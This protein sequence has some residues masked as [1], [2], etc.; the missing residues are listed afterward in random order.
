MK[1][2]FKIA[3]ESPVGSRAKMGLPCWLKAHPRVLCH[4][5]LITMGYL[6]MGAAHNRVATALRRGAAP[7]MQAFP[8]TRYQRPLNACVP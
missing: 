1:P 2:P 4:S 6:N 8:V 3:L 5:E 7:L